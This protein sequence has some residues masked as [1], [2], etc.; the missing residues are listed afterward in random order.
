MKK[1]EIILSVAL[2]GL[3]IGCVS[4]RSSFHRTDYNNNQIYCGF[5]AAN[6]LQ[7]QQVTGAEA[8]EA[9]EAAIQ[10]AVERS[11]GIKLE[12]GS[13]ILVMQS[14]SSLPDKKLVQL[15]E[16]YFRP[17]PYSGL[18][19]ELS[20]GVDNVTPLK[21]SRKLRLN[22]AHAGADF[23]LVYWG[24]MEIA[25]EELETKLVSWVPVLDM[26]VPDEKQKLRLHLK[27]VLMDVR[28]GDWVSFRTPPHLSDT[29]T[30]S[31]ARDN[32]E[33][34]EVTALKDKAYLDMTEALVRQ[35]TV[36]A[37]N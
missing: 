21:L 27:A 2:I 32:I 4:D 24:E 37:G 14:G 6:Q 29:V 36:T 25:R 17:I 22:A 7:E 34:E 31:F 3:S 26:V 10:K 23:V 19:S 1:L 30:T 8:E 13:G 5:N 18:S 15:L 28:S 33:P 20:K 12:K 16:T 9:T 35:Y 11:K